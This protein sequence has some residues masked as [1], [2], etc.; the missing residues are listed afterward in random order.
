MKHPLKTLGLL[1][2]GLLAVP[3]ALLYAGG[4]DADAI[5]QAAKGIAPAVDAAALPA[6]GEVELTDAQWKSRLTAKQYYILREDG[7]ERPFSS[8]LNQVHEPGVFACAAC[9]N[10]L[11]DQATKFDSGT[12]WPSFFAPLPT[13][14]G[15]G[16]RVAFTADNS[17]LMARTEIACARCGGHLGHVFADGPKPTGLRYCM[18]GDAMKFVPA[19]D[20]KPAD[21]DVPADL[22]A[23]SP[24][25][26]PAAE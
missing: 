10:P 14:D 24:T 25:T 1:A 9:G 22:A 20:V 26:R 12:G 23:A 6:V 4:G 13:P 7:T 2:A 8:D 5:A 3:A 16:V 21:F 15:H 11:Y 18:D 19:A 17:A